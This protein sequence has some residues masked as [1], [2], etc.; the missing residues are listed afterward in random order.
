METT[1]KIFTTLFFVLYMLAA[2]VWPTYRTW[3]QTGINP[4]SFGNN[5][6]THDLVGKWF[7]ITI[8]LVPVNILCLWLGENVYRYTLTAWYLDND[9]LRLVGI[10]LCVASWL[11][12]V[13]AQYQM[14]N[15]WRIGIDEA[16]KSAFVTKGLFGLSRNPI[17]F[18][19]LLT[20]MGFLLILLNALSLL[21][22]ACGYLLMQVQIRL[23]EEFLVKQYGE[24]YKTYQQKVRRW[25]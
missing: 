14:G 7:K 17:F 15:S 6:N 18:G 5:D 19:M 25:I 10:V 24:E 11:W 23:E 12:T 20:L 21:A 4:L 13:V 8:G 9:S 1:I 3:K 22:L 2:F 16:N